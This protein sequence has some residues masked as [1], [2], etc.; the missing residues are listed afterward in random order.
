LLFTLRSL[1]AV[2]AKQYT[3]AYYSTLLIS[4]ILCFGVIDEVSEDL[5]RA[6]G[7]VQAA[8]RRSLW[9]VTALLLA[10]GVLLAVLA[11]GDNTVRWISG[12]SVVDRGAAIVQC[13]LLVSLLLA[14]RFLGLRW[15]RPTFG[16]AL[17]LGVLTSVDLAIRAI[18]AE[19]SS[20][21][22]ISYLDFLATGSYL[23]C[24]SIWIGYLVLPEAKPASVAAVPNDEEV[25][26]W[27]RELRQLLRH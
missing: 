25:E 18:R 10:A 20:N 2:T 15:R 26:T 27:N 22:W 1:P 14:S 6:S 19:F 8:A 11:P 17:G 4:I 24:V 5:F 12:M 21:L 16:I 13:G 7:G 9:S 3:Y 23:V